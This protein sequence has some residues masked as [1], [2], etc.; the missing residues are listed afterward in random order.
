VSSHLDYMEGLVKETPGQAI[1][2]DS[3]AQV[4]AQRMDRR[5]TDRVVGSYDKI[6]SVKPAVIRKQLDDAW[7]DYVKH[8][9][10]DASKGFDAQKD[11]V[12][13][14]MLLESGSYKDVRQTIDRMRSMNTQFPLIG[15][16]PTQVDYCRETLLQDIMPDS[17][18]FMSADDSKRL[19]ALKQVVFFTATWAKPLPDVGPLPPAYLM[20][21]T[22]EQGG[23]RLNVVH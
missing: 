9:R 23:I 2:A 15:L 7:N 11:S 19:E 17:R 1:S 10:S 6:Y 22:I 4:A 20:N 14:R 21:G 16:T 3:I 12:P 13:F 18:G 5:V 8:V